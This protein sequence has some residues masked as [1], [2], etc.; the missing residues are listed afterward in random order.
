MALE[1]R[2]SQKSCV[3]ESFLKEKRLG[4]ALTELG[5]SSMEDQSTRIVWI[6]VPVQTPLKDDVRMRNAADEG[7][8]GLEQDCSSK[9][10]QIR[11]SAPLFH[12][13]F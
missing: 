3:F 11:R 2:C 6:T 5:R 13:V 8:D 12:T 7:R 10:E 9:R 4:P 1:S